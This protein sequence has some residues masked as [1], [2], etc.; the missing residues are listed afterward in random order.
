M[1]LPEGFFH[2][3]LDLLDSYL[4]LADRLL[5]LS[6][7]AKPFIA[8]QYASRFLDSTFHYVCLATHDG[9]SCSF[10]LC[11]NAENKGADALDAGSDT[12]M[13]GA[14]SEPKREFWNYL[15]LD[16]I[17]NGLVPSVG[18]EQPGITESGENCA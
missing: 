3:L 17:R 1:G 18:P 4:G 13:L 6:F 15:P 7:R 12:R 16:S 10:G 11:H 8:G 9:D 5:G 14:P 2:G